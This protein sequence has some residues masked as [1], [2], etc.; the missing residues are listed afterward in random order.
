MTAANAEM[1]LDSAASTQFKESQEVLIEGLKKISTLVE[2]L[3]T[4][5]TAELVGQ[6]LEEPAITKNMLADLT[7]AASTLFVPTIHLQSER[8]SAH[9]DRVVNVFASVK[10]LIEELAN[11]EPKYAEGE[12]F[13][14]Y[15]ADD[16]FTAKMFK[17]PIIAAAKKIRAAKAKAAKNSQKGAPA[18]PKTITAAQVN[19]AVQDPSA[20]IKNVISKAKDAKKGKAKVTETGPTASSSASNPPPTNPSQVTSV[21]AAIA[22]EVAKAVQEAMSGFLGK[23]PQGQGLPKGSGPSGKGQK[24]SAKGSYADAAKSAAATHQ[25]T[26]TEGEKACS[27]CGKNGHTHFASGNARARDSDGK[28]AVTEIA[29]RARLRDADSGK[30]ATC[31]TCKKSGHYSAACKPSYVAPSPPSGKGKG[32]RPQSQ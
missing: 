31:N 17:A 22:S 32:K 1:D 16:K 21:P 30:V 25:P 24:K 15:F 14:S 12:D 27:Y 20:F 19:E 8:E 11:E 10:N 9:C 18:T 29:C 6:V 4:K 26:P 3:R 7:G 13:L 28:K 23:L 5:L 2:A